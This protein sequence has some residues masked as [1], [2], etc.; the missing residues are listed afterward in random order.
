M[1]KRSLVGSLL[2]ALA[3]ACSGAVTSGC[4]AAAAGAAAGVGAVKYKQGKLESTASAS[5]PA[6]QQATVDAMG[7]L[8]L[9]VTSQRGDAATARV[10]SRY[11]D[12]TN[13]TVDM[14]ST[15]PSATSIGIRVGTFGDQSRSEQLINAINRELQRQKTASA[16]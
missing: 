12:G 2:V 4:V 15:G 11:S 9:P 16:E 14:E 6:V 5:V 3:V 10:E 13:V 8:N 7:R 1:K